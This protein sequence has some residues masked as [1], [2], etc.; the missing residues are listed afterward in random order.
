[1]NLLNFVATYPNEESCKRKW[2]E[3]RDK[4]GVICPKC[5][6]TSHYW[7]SDKE[8]YE[9]KSCGYRQSLKANT[10]MHNS[11]LPFRYWFIAIH[12]ITSTKKSFSALELQRQLGHNRYDPIWYMLHKL[13]AAMGNRDDKYKLSGVIE[14]DEGFFSTEIP[15]NEKD[16]P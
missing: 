9:C 8:N 16:T 5:G 2:K 11:N 15:E 7:K 1:M 13:R 14:L 10:V 3:M 6:C 12:L 4:Q